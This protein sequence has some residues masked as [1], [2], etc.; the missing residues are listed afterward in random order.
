[1]V[2]AA[3]IHVV[4]MVIDVVMCVIIASMPIVL[5]ICAVVGKTGG[6][7]PEP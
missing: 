1:M 3:V 7:L 4:S 5:D 6:D 2:V